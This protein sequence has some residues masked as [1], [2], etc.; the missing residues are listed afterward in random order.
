MGN[1]PSTGRAADGAL[2]TPLDSRFRGNDDEIGE[3]KILLAQ[4]AKSPVAGRVKTRLQ[5]PLSAE[6]AA[7]LHG[8]MVK[9]AC[10]ELAGAGLGPVELWVDGDASAPLFE[11]CKAMGI[12]SLH[13][14]PDGD[15]GQRMAHIARRALRKHDAV[16]LVGSDC[17]A[18][19]AAYLKAARDA[20]AAAPLV[21]G[22]AQDGGYV[23]AGMRVFRPGLFAK[24]PWGTAGVL[25]ATLA[26]AKREGL[27]AAQLP[28]LPDIDRPEDLRHLPQA[29][30]GGITP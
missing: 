20:L 7:A 19:D 2:V 6:Q 18:L 8:L 21:L 5:P 27:A 11:E 15:L 17:P 26:A 24:I 25:A 30:R 16:I 1:N 9:R 23:L 13:R 10:S 22:P 29:M 14:Q 12:H 4:L 28:P 3:S